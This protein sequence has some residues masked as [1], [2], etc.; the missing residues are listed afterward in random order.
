MRALK[1]TKDA[2]MTDVVTAAAGAPATAA[3]VASGQSRLLVPLLALGVFAII[4]TEMGVVGMVPLISEYFGVS[5]PAA[6][7]SVTIFALVITLSGPTMPLLFSRFNRKYVLLGVLIIFVASCV[8]AALTTSFALHLGMRALA[9]LFHPV[10]VS[11]AFSLAAASVTP[12]ERPKAIAR[13]F[14]G[15]SAGMVLGVPAA[16]YIASELSYRAAMFFFAASNG[17]VLGLTLLIVPSMP[18]TTAQSYGAQLQVLKRGTVWLAVGATVFTNGSTFGFFSYF[19][20]FMETLGGF[21]GA[22]VS[23]ALCLYGGANIV[24]NLLA[25]KLLAV[26]PRLAVALTPWLV[27]AV[28]LTLYLV[29]TE[30]MVALAVI[31]VFGIINGMIG[32][33]CQYLMSKAAPSAPELSNGLFLSSANCG[34]A[35]GTALCGLFIGS[36]GIAA[37]IIG[38]LLMVVVSATVNVLTLKALAR[39][40]RRGES[41]SKAGLACA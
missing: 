12:A 10:Y 7:W 24:G 39:R 21:T 5:I 31:V 9:A 33:N 13:I 6:G 8:V 26:R 4:N 29:I 2:R 28:I 38:A 11:L 37:S 41:A 19:A 22:Q 36:W 20:D 30:L 23:L 1:V 32:N 18:V 34:T 17:L 25:G 3:P 40:E 27:A 35:L 16:S 14:M 15:V